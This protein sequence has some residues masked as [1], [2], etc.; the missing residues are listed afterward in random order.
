MDSF[1]FVWV[2]L[3]VLNLGWISKIK[4][5]EP[6]LWAR[7]GH[8]PCS[9]LRSSYLAKCISFT[10]FLLIDHLMDEFWGLDDITGDLHIFIT[11]HLAAENHPSS[12]DW[13]CKIFFFPDV[14]FC[15]TFTHWV[16]NLQTEAIILQKFC[17]RRESPEPQGQ[18]SQPEGLASGGGALENLAW[19]SAAFYHRNSTGLKE[20]STPLL[21]HVH[22]ETH[23]K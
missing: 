18:S 20:A 13:F 19:M 11:I 5:E 3:C 4:P 9:S 17:H 1:Q 23:G 12:R 15:K 22:T 8:G 14:L 6:M 16:G 21:G 7:L 10:I 2:P